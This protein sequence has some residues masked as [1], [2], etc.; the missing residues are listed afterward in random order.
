MPDVSLFSTQK[1]P[2]FLI[3][4]YNSSLDELLKVFLDKETQNLTTIGDEFTEEKLPRPAMTQAYE[5]RL[6]DAFE[7]LKLPAWPKEI[8]KSSHQLK[9]RLHQYCKKVAEEKRRIKELKWL[10][11]FLYEQYRLEFLKPGRPGNQTFESR[12]RPYLRD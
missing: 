8:P 4:C 7:S 6:A 10:Y 5:K 3:E 12:D 11:V 9:Y 1:D 2:N